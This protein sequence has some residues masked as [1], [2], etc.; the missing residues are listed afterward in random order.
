MIDG[1]H[2]PF[3]ENIALT[4]KVVDIAHSVGASVEGELVQLA[5]L[6]ILL[7]A[8]LQKLFILSQKMQKF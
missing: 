2:L 6:E 3:E 8:E 7:K 1:S 4:K 5:Q